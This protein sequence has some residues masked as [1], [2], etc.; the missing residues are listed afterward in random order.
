[1]ANFYSKSG[2]TI[3]AD[4]GISLPNADKNNKTI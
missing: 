2:I 1:M 3:V 4:M